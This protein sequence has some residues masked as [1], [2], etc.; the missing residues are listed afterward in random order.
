MKRISNI[1]WLMFGAIMIG[2]LIYLI[3][4]RFLTDHISE[5][6]IRYTKA[7]IIN[8]KNYD[9]N[10]RVTSDYSYSYSFTIEG[11]T[12]TGN[13]HDQSLRVGDTIEIEYD[14]SHPSLNKPLHPKE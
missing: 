10:N 13:S 11:S 6:N 4:K 12:Y 3:G 14:K 2:Y 8:H 7:V 5:N 1:G 9:I